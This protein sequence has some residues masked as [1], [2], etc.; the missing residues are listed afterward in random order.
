L[1][2][3]T[4]DRELGRGGMA[5]VYAG[6]HESLGRPVA[7]KV[8][9]AHLAGDP[10]FTARFL[11]EARI[12][13]RLS[14]PNLVKTYD[15]TEH[16]GLPCIVMELAPGGTLE[17]G[18]L[19]RDEA[20]HVA[21]GLAYAHEQGVV[22]RDLKPAN[23]L[24]G[25][26]GEPKVADFG[27]AKALDETQLTETGAIIGT[28]RYLA[29]EQAAGHAAGPEAD[30]YALGVVLDEL[31]SEKAPADVALLDRCRATEPATRPTAAEVGA[32]L[33][34]E[35]AVPETRVL[36]RASRGRRLPLWIAAGVVAIAAGAGGAAVAA[37]GHDT[38]PVTPVPHAASTEQQARNLARW[39]E[40]YSR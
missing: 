3:Y 20:A 2:T 29:P 30:V 13:A 7:L 34:S 17:G 15:I 37:R 26:D 16:D 33:G 19:T 24:R 38:A 14:H 23:I 27:I 5:V 31:L 18:S 32:A 22:H 6:R 11:R 9:A 8:L 35:T 25:G 4:I 40:R 10:R 21:A 28:L 39:L 36:H 12:A 1:S